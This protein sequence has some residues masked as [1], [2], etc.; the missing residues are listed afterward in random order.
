[1]KRDIAAGDRDVR[2]EMKPKVP[3]TFE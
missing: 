3:G 1:M 2:I